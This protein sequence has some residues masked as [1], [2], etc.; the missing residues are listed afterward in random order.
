M[1]GAQAPPVP[2]YVPAAHDVAVQLPAQVIPSAAHRLLSQAFVPEVVQ[3]PELLQTDAVVTLPAE[4]LAAVHS[5][6]LPG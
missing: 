3:L 6:E 4:H 1:V 2:Q 5:V